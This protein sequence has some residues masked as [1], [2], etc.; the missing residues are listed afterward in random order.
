MTDA[1]VRSD[2]EALMTRLVQAER[3]LMETRQQ[4]AAVPTRPTPSSDVRHRRISSYT[5]TSSCTSSL[6]PASRASTCQS[7]VV[8]R[9]PR[10]SLSSRR[11]VPRRPLH[12]TT[13][14]SRQECAGHWAC[15]GDDEDAT[16]HSACGLI[17]HRCG[18][19]ISRNSVPLF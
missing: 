9:F 5:P 17:A 14:R 7:S 6:V 11:M 12:R 1:Q 19:R 15:P 13:S 2:M 16:L 10:S 3:A 18:V 8:T 4:V